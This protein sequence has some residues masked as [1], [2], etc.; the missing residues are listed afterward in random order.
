M[1]NILFIASIL[2]LGISCTEEIDIDLNS[3]NPQIV[4]E[5]NVANNDE[6][7]I[8]KLSYSVN[9]DESNTFPKVEGAIV[10]LSDD[11]GNMELLDEIS[12]GVYSTNTLTGRI[13]GT[14]YLSV[15]KD[16]KILKSKSTIPDQVPF[17]SLI[18]EKS[19]G[20]EGPGGM[21]PSI[22]YNI[23]VEYNDP[24]NE[25]NYYRFVEL[26]NNEIKS[27]YVFDDRITNGS[28][29]R[30]PLISFNRNLSIGDTLKVI[31]QCIDKEVYDYFNSFGNLMG[32]PAN[33]STPANPYTN[34]EGGVL[35]YFSA[36][37][38]EQKEVIIQ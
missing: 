11:L 9:F 14:Y 10:E 31:M 16:E 8:I 32:G 27:T 1:K 5:G 12:P 28:K 25:I 30:S 17:D 29:T 18:V 34:I 19:S 38:Y 21:G 23:F 35:G 22:N 33:S 20:M 24:E 7:T 2:L 26:V 4:V 13:G 3:S 36:H 37:T 15:Q 6:T